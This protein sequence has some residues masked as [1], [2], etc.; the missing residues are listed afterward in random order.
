MPT[1]LPVRELYCPSH[2]GNSY[3]AAMRNEM[4]E[5]LAEAKF[6]GYTR[7]SDWFDTIDLRNV[8]AD[9]DAHFDM[10]QAVWARKFMGFEVAAE[11]GLELGLVVT[12][13]HVFSDQVTP[14]NEASKA[15]RL[16]GQLVCPSKPGVTE[17]IL[18]NYRN[19]FED[20]ARRG[21]RLTSIS[22]GAYD[23][24][25]CACEACRPW[26]VAFGKLAKAIV[27]VG[28]EVFGSVQADLWGWWW[29]DE[30][31]EDFSAWADREARGRFR[32]FT[33][34]ILYG[35]TAYKVRRLP[36][37]MAE[38]AFVHIGYGN[39]PGT[40]V[41]G[42]YGSTV[43]AERLEKTYRYL[44]ARGAD[45]FL[46]YSEGAFDEINKA[47][48]GGLSSGQFET[49][50]DALRAYADRHLG[51]S[52]A[53][54]AAWLTKLGDIEH[55]DARAARTEFES[56][57]AEARPSERLLALDLKL[58]MREADEAVRAETE[59]TPSRLRAGDAFFAAKEKLWRGI[60]RRGL[61]RHIFRFDWKVPDWYAGYA[62]AARHSPE[63]GLAE[64]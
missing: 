48:M 23:Y 26:I 6:W 27:E 7:Y 22:A 61:C 38:R 10:P 41:Y 1:S 29:T 4:R 32:G 13:N 8:Y 20:F 35:E 60:W 34:H 33:N 47:I 40:D 63:S 43:A 19:L 52:S 16:F 5:L 59:W 37:G 11:L 50:N 64:V 53:G 49:A 15:Q 9:D 45:G 14:A 17:M 56:L 2:F 36:Q 31:H 21:L 46:A 44:L 30:D 39:L 42:H 58:Q 28:E 62:G 3:E 12:P 55:L 25:G 54:W 51:G 24:G 18:A 57:R